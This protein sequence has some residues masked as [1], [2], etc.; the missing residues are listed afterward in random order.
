MGTTA[1]TG[2]GDREDPQQLALE[3]V[4]V[5]EKLCAS[6]A[7][8]AGAHVL[9]IGCGTG[10][11]AIAAARRRA[12]VTGV[13]LSEH[14]L[15]RAR[16]RAEAEGLS[17]IEFLKADAA[18]M[19]F[20]AAGFDYVLS[21]LGFVFLPDQEGA[22]RELAR[23]MRPGGVI[24]LTVYTR[25]SLPSHIYDFLNAILKNPAAPEHPHYTWSD[26]AQVREL[27]GPYFHNIRMRLDSYDMCFPS[28]A[29]WFEHMSIWHPPTRMALQRSTSEGRQ[30]VRDGLIGFCERYNRATDGSLMVNM[31][32][33]IIT[34]VRTG[35]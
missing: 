23:V 9:D 14:A 32:Y 15:A 4:I 19:P 21:T 29:A 11:T 34:A 2:S 3:T 8:P 33:A 24:A 5:S 10:H 6:L 12:I 31:D 17:S 35:R 25:Q 13:D 28:A 1:A 30:T 16:L 7:I 20:P 18:A 27:L 26:G 22:A